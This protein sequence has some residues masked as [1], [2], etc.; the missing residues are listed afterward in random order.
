MSSTTTN[1]ARLPYVQQ[2]LQSN[3]KPVFIKVNDLKPR[4]VSQHLPQ[5]QIS[6]SLT[7]RVL[8]LVNL[9]R[10]LRRVFINFPENNKS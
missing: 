6:E 3:V 4:S 8:A 2:A 1:K 7:C 5:T 10:Y 9:L